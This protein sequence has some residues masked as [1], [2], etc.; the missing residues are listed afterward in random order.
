MARRCVIDLSVDLPVPASAAYD[1]L[2]DIQDV[3]PIPR[4][5]AVRMVKEPAGATHCGTRW[6]ESVRFLPG[7]WMHVESIA[8]EV[9]EPHLL[10][11]DFES[12]W[13]SGHLRY[14]IEDTPDGCRLHHRETLTPNR[15][16]RPLT[17]VIERRLGGAIAQRLQDIRAVL[18]S[19][20]PLPD[21][22]QDGV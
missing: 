2:A 11:M 15:L 5:A 21:V 13:W 8:T 3:E 9:S 20:A 6:H 7:W 19:R 22:P 12:W 17:G 18:L 10:G 1:L 16:L 14:E 4:R